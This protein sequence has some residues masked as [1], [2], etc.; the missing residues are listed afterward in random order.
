MP[1][2]AGSAVAAAELSILSIGLPKMTRTLPDRTKAGRVLNEHVGPVF[3]FSA[4]NAI[5]P[6]EGRA[7]RGRCS[8][9]PHCCCRQKNA[10]QMPPQLTSPPWE[11]TVPFP[12]PK[13]ADV[14]RD[15]KEK[16]RDVNCRLIPNNAPRHSRSHRCVPSQRRRV[17]RQTRQEMLAL[18]WE[19]A[20]SPV[21]SLPHDNDKL[22]SST[23]CRHSRSRTHDRDPATRRTLHWKSQGQGLDK[24]AIA[25][26]S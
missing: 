10:R 18:E 1:S 14:H 17:L 22:F 12:G 4:G 5:P 8:E 13:S 2:V 3:P 24:E 9:Q 19:K 21:T 25:E 7:S 15:I 11:V 23:G 20:D 6:Q 26:L 16:S